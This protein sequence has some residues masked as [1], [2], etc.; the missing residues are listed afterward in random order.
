M[1]ADEPARSVH[2]GRIVLTV[3]AVVAAVALVGV[4]A[5][6]AVTASARHGAEQ[7]QAVLR[8]TNTI[9]TRFAKAHKASDLA[10]AKAW[11][12]LDARISDNA[13]ILD[14]PAARLSI[15]DAGSLKDRAGKANK[16]TNTLVSAAR[17]ALAIKQEADARESLAKAVGEATKLRDGA[18]RDDD[19]GTAIDDLTTI[20]E[21]AAEPGKDVTVKELEDL[22]SR[23]EQARKTLE[24]AIATQAEHAKAK[25]AA[26]EKAARERQERERQAEQQTVPDPTPPQQQ[27]QWIPQYQ[28]GQSGQSGGTGSQPGNGW[29]VPAPATATACPATIRDYSPSS[30]R[31]EHHHDGRDTTQRRA[32]GTS[33]PSRAR[34]R[35]ERME[36]KRQALLLA[37]AAAIALAAT[38]A[39]N[40]FQSTT[41]D[42]P[43][44]QSAQQATDSGKDT[45]NS[46]GQTH[47][48]NHRNSPVPRRTS[49][50]RPGRSSTPRTAAT[51]TRS[52]RRSSAT[53]TRTWATRPTCS[54][55]SAGRRRNPLSAHWPTNGMPRRCR[56]PPDTGST[57]SNP[58]CPK[59][60]MPWTGFPAP[61]RTTARVWP[62]PRNRRERWS[63]PDPTTTTSSPP[64]SRPS[65]NRSAHAP[66][67]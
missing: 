12:R 25:R 17:R 39:L 11:S 29:S 5:A 31:K 41:S 13:R 40:P 47:L 37:V 63:T 2:A 21:R 1:D 67:T 64:R 8:E 33:G 43:E 49:P 4:I 19:T 38:I 44:P 59:R 27:Q 48:R 65:P 35:F 16:D 56:R 28:S 7:A 55:R 60:N 52:A 62:R 34:D 9:A 18:K 66:P 53:T 23:V 51:S 50:T 20:L 42:Q 57:I 24:Q 6:G 10:D 58:V 26:E 61:R 3:L 45:K 15:R 54:T 36:P 22:V 32:Q 14:E 30:I 46:P